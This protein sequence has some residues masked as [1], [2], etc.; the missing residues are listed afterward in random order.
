[1]TIDRAARLVSCGILMSSMVTTPAVAAM[2]RILVGFVVDATREAPAVLE[3]A[4]PA[5]PAR[6]RPAAPA[7]RV[8]AIWILAGE[9]VAQSIPPAAPVRLRDGELA[10]MRAAL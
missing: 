6:M 9:T 4:L 8:A 7:A 2:P 1:M 3:I 5:I 10:A